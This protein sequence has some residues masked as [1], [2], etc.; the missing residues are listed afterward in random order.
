MKRVFGSRSASRAATL[1]LLAGIT[2]LA[3]ACTRT[4]LND[5]AGIPVREIAPDRPG[6]V[7]GT[8]PE[9]QDLL[10][11]SDKMLRSIL[12]T[13]AV[14]NATSP[15]TVVLLPVKSNTRFTIN[16]NIFLKRLKATLN[17]QARGKVKF[18]ARDEIDSILA[19]R[20]LKRAGAVEA[21]PERATRAPK[22]ADY[23]LTGSLDGMGQASGGGTSDY[24]L[25]T[26]KLI[27]A[28]TS[29]EVWEDMVEIK[30]EGVDDVVYR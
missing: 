6:V 25:Y 9:S 21:N 8:G 23:F 22:G 27:D 16:K 20:D 5:T 4:N 3:S 1:G 13:P 12:A 26:F 2:L 29:E 18:L 10:R 19:E 15:P 11:V 7:A 28:E 24:I 30:K 17:S 14:A